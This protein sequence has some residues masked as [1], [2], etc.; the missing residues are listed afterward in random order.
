MPGS[1]CFQCMKSLIWPYWEETRQTYLEEM[2]SVEFDRHWGV[3][4]PVR[5]REQS[6]DAELDELAVQAFAWSRKVIQEM[7]VQYDKNPDMR[8]EW[9]TNPRG[10]AGVRG[11]RK[12]ASPVSE[13]LEGEEIAWRKGRGSWYISKEKMAAASERNRY[14]SLAGS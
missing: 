5:S 10:A 12:V 4:K 6:S 1:H 2:G 8:R 14:W 13:Q 11:A 3:R 9:R 7:I